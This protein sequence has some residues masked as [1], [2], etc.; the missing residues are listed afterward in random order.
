MNLMM[1]MATLK[2][3][4]ES[5]EKNE[6]GRG[7]GEEAEA[8]WKSFTHHNGRVLPITTVEFCSSRL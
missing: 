3:G 8:P 2:I 4:R 1:M 5:V 6:D 7:K